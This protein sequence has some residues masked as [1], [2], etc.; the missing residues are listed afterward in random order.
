M[1]DDDD[2][3][4]DLGC[5]IHATIAINKNPFVKHLICMDKWTKTWISL[6]IFNSL[7]CILL[8]CR[9]SLSEGKFF[10]FPSKCCT[11]WLHNHFLCF[12]VCIIFLVSYFWQQ[13]NFALLKC[14][15]LIKLVQQQC[16]CVCVC[17][18]N[19]INCNEHKLHPKK[20]K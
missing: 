17:S 9:K 8:N 5:E 20:I 18:G 1:M 6:I 19:T 14:K 4:D 12:F 3:K 10:C 16:L 2:L 11:L 7:N 13:I 15:W